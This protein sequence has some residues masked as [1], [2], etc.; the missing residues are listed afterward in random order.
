[1]ADKGT[2]SFV[3]S[4]PENYDRYLGPAQFEP[5]ADD[6]A[7]RVA[8][9]RP[10]GAVLETACGTG[11]LTKRL[12]ARLPASVR[13]VATDLNQP[14]LD[15]ARAKLADASIEWQKA[16][17]MTLQFGDASFG[18]TACGF[19]VM[20]VPDKAAAFCEA[21]RVL[22]P[23]GL[24]AFNVWD[25][26]EGNAAARVAQDTVCTFFGGREPEFFK[27]PFGFNDRDFIRRLLSG[28]GFDRIEIEPV[29]VTAMSPSARDYATGIV[30]GT[31]ASHEIQQHGVALDAAVEAV[32]AAL[33]REFGDK[34][35]RTDRRALVI[36][37]RAK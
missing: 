22:A 34:P 26:L 15:Y 3:G 31:P 9:D 2:A 21:R 19:G 28:G 6:L 35:F 18:A 20:F 11:I 10:A 24:F 33:A 25:G 8:N 5:F 1:M 4:I 30:R 27:V 37:A 23:G 36:T 7:G 12:R 13:L 14:M 29:T 16:D 32:T 17:A